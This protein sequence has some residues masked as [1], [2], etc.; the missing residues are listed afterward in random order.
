MR[1]SL[2]SIAAIAALAL[3]ARAGDVGYYDMSLGAGSATQVPP[4]LAAGE[5]PV[6]LT[7][8]TAANLAGI[9]VLFVQ[10]P[11]NLGFGAEYLS[12]LAD[13]QAAVSAGMVLVIHDRF[14]DGAEA[15]LP[16]G[17]AFNVIRCVAFDTANIDILDNTTLVTSGPGGVLDNTSLDG[18][19][20][21][22]HGFI[23]EG[24]L[25]GG[26]V[27][28]LSRT[29]PEEIVLTCYS[30]GAGAVLY[31]SIPLDFY[32]A[33][34]GNNPP[35]DAMNNIYAPNVIA[36]GAAGACSVGAECFLIVG[37][38]RS[39]GSFQD[40]GFTWTTQVGGI[41]AS[42]P[43]LLDDIPSFAMPT[44][45]ALVGR[46]ARALEYWTVQVLMH[47]PEVFPSNP[48]QW[49]NGLE[50]VVGP[51]GF[52]QARPYG[53]SNGIQVWVQTLQGPNGQHYYRF[54][55]SIEGL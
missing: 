4:I 18:G 40:G 48:V 29:D 22:S 45:S 20:L 9:E 34:F 3:P 54:P 30:F 44:I 5:N 10:N 14:V 24:T 36:Y 23:V 2:L 17:G 25:P 35:A 19:N 8:L 16:G 28:I 26:S 49:S 52:V 13:I 32:L 6:L 38:S 39:A 27:D 41:V 12:R 47:N 51:D 46:K 11:D 15:I 37:K 53:T 7:D 43:V 55:F 50:L 21:S 1:S 33:G 42:Y 31:C